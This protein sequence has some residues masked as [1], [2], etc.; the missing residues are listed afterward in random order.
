M[1]RPGR[2][3]KLRDKDRRVLSEGILKKEKKLYTKP[4]LPQYSRWSTTSEL[5]NRHYS[6]RAVSSSLRVARG[7]KRED[8][9][10]PRASQR[11]SMGLRSGE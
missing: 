3:T 1:L 7:G 11:F 10:R 4:K 5:S 2:P 6:C 8:T 9:A